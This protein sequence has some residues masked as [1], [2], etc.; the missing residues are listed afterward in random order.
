MKGELL[1]GIHHLDATQLEELTFSGWVNGVILGDPFC[2]LRMFGHGNLE[3][4]MWAQAA[5]Q[6]GLRVAFQ[7]PVYL[8][9]PNYAGTLELILSMEQKSC[10]DLLLVQDLGLLRSLSEAECRIPICWTIWGVSRGDV[11][12]HHL[13]DFLLGLQVQY[14]ETD[15]AARVGALQSY[16]LKVVYRWRA[17]KVATFGRA[18]YTQHALGCPC[19]EGELCRRHEPVLRAAGDD[20][21]LRASGHTLQYLQPWLNPWPQVVPDCAAV[22]L[23]RA[24]DL[25][26]VLTDEQDWQI[27][28]P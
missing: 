21:L 28:A 9:E 8:T 26:E 27:S 17:P 5:K 11:V 25:R 16:G 3:S 24:T 19:I 20:L 22:Y 14:L 23:R 15:R 10:L 2:P 13:L 7:T 12:S 1:V 4:L 18:C 6:A